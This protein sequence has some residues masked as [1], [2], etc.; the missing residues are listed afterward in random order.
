MQED[1]SSGNFYH[2]HPPVLSLPRN[3]TH[4]ILGPEGILS[5]QHPHKAPFAFCCRL[6]KSLL[7]EPGPRVNRRSFQRQGT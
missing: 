6:F 7:G 4:V 2:P 3:I 1:C 5:F